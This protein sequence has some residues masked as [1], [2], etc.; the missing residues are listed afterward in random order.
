MR[1][2]GAR[3]LGQTIKLSAPLFRRRSTDASRL[4]TRGSTA[5]CALLGALLVGCT[6]EDDAILRFGLP[7]APVS[8]DPRQASDAVSTRLCRLLYESLVDFDTHFT[9]IPA[10]ASWQAITDTQYRFTLASSHRFHDGTAVRA[11]DVVATYRAI[12]DPARAS[13]H[14]SALAHVQAITALDSRTVEFKLSRADPLFPGLLQLGIL[15]AADAAR[16]TISAQPV[17]SGPFRVTHT[18]SPNRLSLTRVRDGQRVDFMT[19]PNETTRA[20]KLARGE[21]DLAQGGFSPE[22]VEW[23][24]EQPSLRVQ[25]RPGTVFSYLGFN[26]ASGPTADPR[27]R[28]AIAQAIDR[29][30]LVKYL[31]KGHARLANSLLVPEHWAGHPSLPPIPYNPAA[32]TQR[33][34]EL[35][36]STRRPLILSYKT[37]NDHFRRRIATVLQAQLH[38]VGIALKIQNYDWGTLYGDIKAGRFELYSLSWVGLQLPDIFRHAFHSSSRPPSGANRGHYSSEVVDR[39]I[40]R[41][42]GAPTRD[43]QSALYRAIQ[44]ELQGDLP[45]VPLWFEDTIVV[46]RSRVLGY[47]TDLN[48]H[49]DGL[50]RI[51]RLVEE[52]RELSN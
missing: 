37:S 3:D 6:R 21:L 49:Y 44:V 33:L 18:L 28:L 26:L 34:R 8:L 15:R 31:F 25:Q 5:I 27:L 39:L 2:Q 46:Q 30:S 42:E 16:T 17:G 19:V 47:D 12:L 9:P 51:S 10:L 11:A 23:L 14:R 50:T 29:Q 20:L 24:D 1:V 41:A 40:E 36:Y 48:G 35:G 4:K 52:S 22:L 32:A 13:P 7:T 43:L 45:Y 38:E